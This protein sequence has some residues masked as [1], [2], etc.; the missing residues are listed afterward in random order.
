MLSGRRFMCKDFFAS[1]EPAVKKTKLP[2]N[3]TTVLFSYVV[4]GVV[5]YNDK[6]FYP[7]D[8]LDITPDMSSVTRTFYVEE[9]GCL[10]CFSLLK[11]KKLK[12]EI[13]KTEDN[14][15]VE[16]NTQIFVIEGSFKFENKILDTYDLMLER[17]YNVTLVGRGVV[18]KVKVLESS[19]ETTD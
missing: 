4:S 13:A 1:F 19:N 9:D 5:R 16:P 17:S 18:A 6:L 10:C 7:G 11:K 12:F 8:W 2:Q 14:I 15:S 3:S